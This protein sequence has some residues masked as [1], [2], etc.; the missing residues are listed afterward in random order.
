MSENS[1]KANNFLNAINKYA[2]E[3][4]NKIQLEGEIY[5]KNELEKAEREALKE[6]YIL[7]QKEMAS[8]RNEIAARISR[9]EAEGRKKLFNKRN[10]ITQEVFSRAKNILIEFTKSENY[11]DFLKKSAENISHLIEN[12]NKILYI[13]EED[14]KFVKI[15]SG[16]FGAKC[17]VQQDNNIKIGGIKVKDIKTG[18]IYDETL[19]TK[20]ENQ[21]EW[22][23]LTCPMKIV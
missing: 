23:I 11:L 2:E 10:R 13:K 17:K 8:M 16:Y 7:I 6:T 18:M 22:F 4:R 21:C 14:Y 15:I 3:Q 12:Y 9:K 1:H 20:L 5:K 19:D